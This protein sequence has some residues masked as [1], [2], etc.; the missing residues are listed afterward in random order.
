MCA[1]VVVKTTSNRETKKIHLRT[2]IIYIYIGLKV[3]TVHSWMGSTPLWFQPNSGYVEHVWP[4]FL[5][6]FLV[7]LCVAAQV[8]VY[9]QTRKYLNQHRVL[10]QE[11]VQ[12]QSNNS[13]AIPLKMISRNQLSP[14]EIT[15][16]QELEPM[17]PS[18]SSVVTPAGNN[19]SSSTCTRS[20]TF[21][22]HR[23][24]KSVSKLELEASKTLIIGILSVFIVTG[25]T[26]Y[27]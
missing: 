23:G 24:N 12:E 13:I 11:P 6:P 15:T 10:N 14:S 16:N 18:S 26:V 27:H 7:L 9:Y 25:I 20:P 19:N 17:G 8:K 2:N 21:F 5:S 4:L 1:V 3:F 22:V